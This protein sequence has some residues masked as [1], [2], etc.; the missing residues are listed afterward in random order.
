[1]PNVL[2]KKGA[3]LLATCHCGIGALSEYLLC[4]GAS[5]SIGKSS[6]PSLLGLEITLLDG[7]PVLVHGFERIFESSI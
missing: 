6:Q 2:L 1:M 3:R 4:R 5:I 7:Q